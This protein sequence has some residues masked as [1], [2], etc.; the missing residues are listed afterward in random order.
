MVGVSHHGDSVHLRLPPVSV[1]RYVQD[2]EDA[3]SRCPPICKSYI[4]T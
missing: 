1:A 3:V 2:Q 4:K